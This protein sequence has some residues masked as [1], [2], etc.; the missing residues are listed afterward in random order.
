MVSVH[1][2][3]PKLH[4]PVPCSSKKMIYCKE[5]RVQRMPSKLITSLKGL[6]HQA[7]LK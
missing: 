7:N 3:L 2:A 6:I 5:F 4:F 1:V